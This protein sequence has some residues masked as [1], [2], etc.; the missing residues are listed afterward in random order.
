MR[1]YLYK[2]RTKKNI[3]NTLLTVFAFTVWFLGLSISCSSEYKEFGYF[4]IHVRGHISKFEGE[5]ALTTI[6]FLRYLTSLF[7]V[8][9]LYFTISAV[10]SLKNR[11]MY[12]PAL[13]REFI[14]C[15]SCSEPFIPGDNGRILCEKC[16]AKAD[17]YLANQP[18][19]EISGSTNLVKRKRTLEENEK[20]FRS[21]FTFFAIVM[22]L[23]LIAILFLQ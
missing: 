23:S 19:R 14:N 17:E 1:G 15:A 20:L 4:F 6:L 11:T 13:K 3:R 8:I 12:D 21:V 9:S 18:L 5:G 2:F 22:S 16:K 10:L 7:I